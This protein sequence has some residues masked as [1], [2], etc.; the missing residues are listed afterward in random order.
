MPVFSCLPSHPCQPLL[1]MLVT[2]TV[3][4][5]SSRNVFTDTRDMPCHLLGDSEFHEVGNEDYLSQ[6]GSM[7]T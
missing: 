6:G 5:P 7:D 1:V 4:L 2:S 3:G